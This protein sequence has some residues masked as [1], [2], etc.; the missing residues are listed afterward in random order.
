MM[1]S[2][3]SSA[4]ETIK[5]PDTSGWEKASAVMMALGMSIMSV[6]GI[7]GSFNKVVNLASL[8][9]EMGITVVEG[10]TTAELKKVLAQ[11]LG[12]AATENLTRAGLEQA[13]V[14]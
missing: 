5:D 6:S 3:I 13:V 7:L 11:K 10:A 2:T 8:A 12:T 9:G 1:I 4:V 14:E